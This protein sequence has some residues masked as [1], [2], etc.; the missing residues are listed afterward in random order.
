MAPPKPSVSKVQ[1]TTGSL[2]LEG[3]DNEA[4]AYG[5]HGSQGSD[6][7]SVRDMAKALKESTKRRRDTRRRKIENDYQVEMEL[8]EAS[9]S[10]KV[11][12][13]T[14][15]LLALHKRRLETLKSV[16]ERRT[17]I[18]EEIVQ[19]TVKLERAFMNANQELRAVLTARLDSS[20]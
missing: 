4:N 8:L 12:H 11:A 7:Q 13:V 9:F 17:D 18:E 2:A 5:L 3:V 16:L 19:S 15:R 20:Q 6:D 14:G 1:I 10:T